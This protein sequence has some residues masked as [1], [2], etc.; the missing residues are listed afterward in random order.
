M[1]LSRPSVTGGGGG[2]IS[3]VT[4]GTAISGGG[5]SGSVTVNLDIS[6]LSD[7]VIATADK[8]LLLDS[9]G[10]TQIVESVDD[11]AG[12]LPAL[13]TEAAIDVSADYMLFLD[14]GS[15]GT[16]KKE[17][18][19]DLAS[20]MAGTGLTASS[21]QLNSSATG[22]VTSIT[23]AADAGSGSAITSSGTLTYTGGT[24]VSTS[25]SGTTVTIDADN[26][27]TVTSIGASS[28][29]GS[30][31]NIT[32]SGTLTF[33]GGTNV[34]TSAT[35]STVTINSTDQYQGTVTS[36]TASSDSG[37]TTAITGS[38]TLTFEGGTNVTT[39]ATG[40]TVTINSADQY[41]GTVT[42]ITAASDS[43]STSAITSSGT[44]TFAGGTNVTTS[45][46]GSTVT[47]NASGGGTDLGGLTEA[48]VN[49]AADSFGFVDAD[50]SNASRR[51]TIADLVAG[52]AG[53]GLS[54]ASGQLSVRASAT[55]TA[56]TTGGTLT[57]ADAAQQ[58]IA[59]QVFS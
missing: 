7:G 4:A 33:A 16:A 40:S 54:A 23:A 49:V 26:N 2:T 15:T 21:G 28:D 20:A 1:A 43:G 37:S 9:D 24:G 3:G 52:I 46:T 53:S 31:S 36:V 50:D 5:T 51:D 13:T 58:V 56:M 42:S 47:I 25:V 38:G 32:S 22:T 34:T 27:G 19:T 14:G 55:A 10:S 45:A 12:K 59:I 17:A 6:E 41:Q 30:T 48:T 8:M 35:G 11:I 39:S 18:L 44:L 29:S 57:A